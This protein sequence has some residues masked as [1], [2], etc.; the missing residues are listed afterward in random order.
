MTRR[1]MILQSVETSTPA[2]P[3]S[4]TSILYPKI[5]GDW[6]TLDSSGAERFALSPFFWTHEDTTIY[7]VATSAASP[8]TVVDVTTPSVAAGD[9]LLRIDLTWNHDAF[10]SSKYFEFLLDGAEIQSIGSSQNTFRREPPD[11]GGTFQSTGTRHK[12]PLVYEKPVTLTAGTHDIEI[13]H[14]TTNN[15][16][17]S[18]WDI[19]ISLK[20]YA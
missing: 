16:T 2:T 5:D 8:V 20:R 19:L 13:Q 18:V 15:H 12:Y 7:S 1:T 10:S 6:Y 9:Y 11:H 4:G 3:P 17:S 14:G